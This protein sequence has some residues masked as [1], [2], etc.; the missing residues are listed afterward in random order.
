MD[1]E[2]LSKAQ[3][4]LLMILVNFVTSIAT[5]VLTV[6][7]LDQAPA[8]VTQ[9]VNRIVDHTIETVATGTPLAAVIAPLPA[10]VKTTVINTDD[11]RMSAIAAAAVR[12]VGIY[13]TTGTS[14]PLIAYGTY[15][16]EAHAIVTATVDGL[17]KQV[18]IVFPDSSVHSASLSHEGATLTIYGFGDTEKL[19][20]ATTPLIISHTDVK[21]GESAVAITGDGS[22]I[23]GIV[24]KVDADGVHTNLAVTP[25]GSA[26][27]D[28]S[29]NILGISA[30]VAG[31][32]FPADKIT[33]L[34][35]ATT[36]PA[37]S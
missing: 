4:I 29:G 2:E 27:V 37:S 33:T 8:N 7:L 9:T 36:S 15:L 3:L 35:S 12:T 20:A 1:I 11:L 13:S 14:S 16:P 6:S 10:A 32:Y 17:P 5:G 31:L 34:L 21:Q 25:A 28:L 18:S 26:A 22:A 24:S 30:G 19:P 23:T